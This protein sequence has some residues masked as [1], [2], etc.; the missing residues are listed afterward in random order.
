[1]HI[2]IIVV[3]VCG[4]ILGGC[5]SMAKKNDT[6]NIQGEKATFAGGCFRCWLHHLKEFMGSLMLHLATLEEQ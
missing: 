1:M 4:L 6:K 3:S 5:G 2:K